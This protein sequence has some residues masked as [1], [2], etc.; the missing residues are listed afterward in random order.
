MP[1]DTPGVTTACCSAGTPSGHYKINDAWSRTTCGS[2]SSLTYNVCTYQRY[3]DKPIGTIMAICN[4][5]PLAAG[6]LELNTT[7][8]P[9]ACGN[10]PSSTQNMQTV[11]RNH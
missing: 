11:R 10:P 2:P 7:W 6:W 4:G 8:N 5:Q 3:D 1:V 9:T